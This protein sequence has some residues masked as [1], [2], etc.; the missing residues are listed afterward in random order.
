MDAGTVRM[1]T[2]IADRYIVQEIFAPFL[3]GVGAFL[4]I[5]VGDILY[6][7]AEFIASR[8]VGI[9]TVVELLIYKLPAILVI[10][11]P[12]S[13]L[14]GIVLGLG[15]L[16]KDREIQA[17][18]LAGFSLMRIFVP[19]F[20]FGL[21]T[22]V[23]TFAINEIVAPWANRQANAVIRKAAF[24]DAFPQIRE[25]VFFR[26]PGNRVYYIGSVDD[27][28]QEL[29]S[30]MIYELEGPVP[31]LI[32]AD[33]A[34]WEG[35][36]WHLYAGVVREL[37]EQGFTHYEAGFAQMDLAVGVEGGAFFAGQ[38]TP[39]EMTDREFHQYVALF[40]H[41]PSNARVA[42]RFYEKFGVPFVLASVAL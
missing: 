12:V 29:R 16:A 31:R 7:L 37:D 25:Q 5:L 39:E 32:T 2:S 23:V 20:A 14:V 33:S 13:T 6:T 15:R 40:I 8:Q 24:A 21:L 34:R 41:V 22:T 35:P 10:T 30:V 9:R 27:A 3:L 11:F 42:V 4:V 19:V 26:G 17:M 1:R 28:H 36:V 38:K 18:R